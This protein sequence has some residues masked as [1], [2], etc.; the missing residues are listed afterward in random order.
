MIQTRS[1]VVP[2]Y[3]FLGE[4]SPTRIEYRKKGTLMYILTSLLE[5]L[6]YEYIYIYIFLLVSLSS[7][8]QRGTHA[9][10]KHGPY[11]FVGHLGMKSESHFRL[12]MQVEKKHV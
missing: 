3:P 4:G 8:Q 2:F 10:L 5:D 11:S 6:V 9:H 12:E 1:P 7:H